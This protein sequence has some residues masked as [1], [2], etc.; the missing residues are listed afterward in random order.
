[1]QTAQQQIY[2]QPVRIIL[3]IPDSHPWRG[4]KVLELVRSGDRSRKCLVDQPWKIFSHE[5]WVVDSES[6]W[7]E[8]AKLSPGLLD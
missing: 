7:P 2:S 6:P 4:G 8:L 5:E 1:M 3:P